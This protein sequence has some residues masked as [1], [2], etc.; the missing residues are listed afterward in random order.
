MFLLSY[1][2]RLKKLTREIKSIDRELENR[3]DI[4]KELENKLEHT[5]DQ[6]RKRK[7]SKST[8]EITIEKE[9]VTGLIMIIW[10]F[11]SYAL[12]TAYL[13]AGQIVLK[14][15]IN[16]HKEA[17]RKYFT[18]VILASILKTIYRFIVVIVPIF[19]IFW[20]KD[21]DSKTVSWIL[22]FILG[23]MVV[24]FII[25]AEQKSNKEIGT[26]IW[27]DELGIIQSRYDQITTDMLNKVSKAIPNSKE[28]I[29]ETTYIGRHSYHDRTN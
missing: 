7:V 6:L 12:H 19:A 1:K 21:L 3:Y 26:S 9:D 5:S 11:M 4:L 25:S 28:Y 8:G 15:R 14:N 20:R 18:H 23:A 27:K 10:Q 13:E 2:D 22:C 16:K 29:G 24:G 17:L